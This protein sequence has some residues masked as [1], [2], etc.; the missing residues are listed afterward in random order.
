VLVAASLTG[1]ADAAS[2]DRC[3]DFVSLSTPQARYEAADTVVIA[4]LQA[5]ART[6]DSF[7]TY[8]V[9]RATTIA[10]VKGATPATFD[11]IAP[12]DQCERKGAPAEYLEGDPL[13]DV[14]RAV[15]YLVKAD[16]YWKL[17]TPSSI[18]ALPRGTALPFATAAPS[19]TTSG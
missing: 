9:H 14:D 8:S 11:V 5:T 15:L 1:C 3:V 17:I 4:T 16:R 13:E 10:V 7:A 18:D 19:P 12:S 6:V 2:S